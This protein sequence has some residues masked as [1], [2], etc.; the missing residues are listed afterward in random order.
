MSEEHLIHLS[1]KGERCFCGAD[2]THKVGEERHYHDPYYNYRHNFTQY[3]CCQCF[4]N[5]L[6][7]A[8]LCGLKRQPST[9][10]REAGLVAALE[11]YANRKRRIEGY[12]WEVAEKALKEYRGER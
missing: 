9:T 3:V 8:T 12:D 10:D 11:M 4:T 7:N 2:A 6:G 5:I 1:A